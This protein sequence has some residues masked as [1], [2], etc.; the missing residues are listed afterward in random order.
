MCLASEQLRRPGARAVIA[1]GDRDSS[2]LQVGHAALST[3]S[4]STSS[5]RGGGPLTTD[6]LRVEA[7][8]MA[9]TQE[10]PAARLP[11]NGAASVRAGR[12]QRSNSVAASDQIG[13][14]PRCLGHV[15]RLTVRYRRDGGQL[16]ARRPRRRRFRRACGFASGLGMI[17]LWAPAARCCQYRG[18]A[19]G[20]PEGVTSGYVVH[21]PPRLGRPDSAP[22]LYTSQERLRFHVT[23]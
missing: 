23:R 13:R 10:L 11:G 6:P 8:A 15:D 12:R 7:A 14:F 17:Q 4:W 18:K 1:E 3:T 9:G 2:R 22:R 21:V 19:G 20:E 5:A 16:P